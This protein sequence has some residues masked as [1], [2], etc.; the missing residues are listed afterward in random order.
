[1][2]IYAHMVVRNEAD[3]F[4]QA[5]LEWNRQW[6]DVLHVYDGRSDDETVKIAL[7]Y[8]NKVGIHPEGGPGFYEHEGVYRQMAWDNFDAMCE[9]EMGDWVFCL[10]ADEFLVGTL[11]DP[12]PMESLLDLAD[13]A[14]EM[15]Y[16]ST[17]IARAEIWDTSGEVP[18][19]RVD[20]A[21][22]T[23]RPA[24]YVRWEPNAKIRQ[25]KLG[26]GSVPKYGLNGLTTLHMCSILHFG[27]S[28]EGETKRKY[29]LYKGVVGDQHNPNHIASIVSTPTLGIWNGPVPKW[30]QGQR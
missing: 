30:W 8:T 4:L 14:E 1:M 7:K 20:G 9:P 3:R 18:L 17:C 16:K 21:W 26:C 22:G 10:D 15:N 25:A 24:R 5:S 19:V 28:V 2:T 27:Y 29:D 6:F 23:D 12:N 13:A 11:K